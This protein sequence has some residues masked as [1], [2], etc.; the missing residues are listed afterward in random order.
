[1]NIGEN[2]IVIGPGGRGEIDGLRGRAWVEAAEE[3][4]AEVDGTSPRDGL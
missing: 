2:L 4:G 3:E 1:M